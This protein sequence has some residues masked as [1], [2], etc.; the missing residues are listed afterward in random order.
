MSADYWT[1][2][3]VWRG[4]EAVVLASGP[5]ATPEVIE[6]LR[7]RNVIVV[8]STVLAA[9]WAPVWFFRDAA[10]LLS[11][12]SGQFLPVHA[13]SG[14]NMVDFARSFPGMVVTT[15]R[16]VKDTVPE[17][18]MVE[19]PRM[20]D[21][22]PPGSPT[23]RHGKSS[24]HAAI[25]LAIAMGATRVELHGFD[26]RVVDGREHHHQEYEGRQRNL[27]IYADRF[28]PEFAGWNEA[29]KRAGVS[30]VNATPGSAL[31]EFPML[32]GVA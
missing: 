31:R 3:P 14:E 24:G 6:A 10:V 32:E 23:I 28:L 18:R 27:S 26:M 2:E 11:R 20:K 25:S 1:P 21:F 7:G 5:S 22:P 4:Q 17:V 16:R 29:A 19:A 15:S 30:V 12:A 13:R 9:R 8:N